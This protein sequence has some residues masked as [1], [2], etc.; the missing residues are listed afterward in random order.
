MCPELAAL[1]VC[2]LWP[3]FG[4]IFHEFFTPLVPRQPVEAWRRNKNKIAVQFM[5]IVSV[6][7]R[8]L[9]DIPDIVQWACSA[10]SH[11]CKYKIVL[12]SQKS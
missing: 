12:V 8:K 4:T 9:L 3:N 11:N 10:N 6:L 7:K 1:H 5:F 2:K